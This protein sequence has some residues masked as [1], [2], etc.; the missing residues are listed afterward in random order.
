MSDLCILKHINYYCVLLDIFPTGVEECMA[1]LGHRDRHDVP[2]HPAAGPRNPPCVAGRPKAFGS[3]GRP[4]DLLQPWRI[5]LQ[6]LHLSVER[7]SSPQ[8]NCANP[9]I[10]I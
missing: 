9:I 1:P 2:V 5:I 8:V 7:G 4:Y 3:H 10:S 6:L